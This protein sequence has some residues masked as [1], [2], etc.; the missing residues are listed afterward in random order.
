[1]NNEILWIFQILLAIWFVF[2]SYKKLSKPIKKNFN[3]EQSSSEEVPVPIIILGILEFIGAIGILISP[4]FYPILTAITAIC[5]SIVMFGASIVHIKNK[6]YK[7]LPIIILALILSLLV[8]YY[9][10]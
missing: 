7:I 8:A 2:G 6:S 9:R 1:M 4:F 3:K 10:F 5:F